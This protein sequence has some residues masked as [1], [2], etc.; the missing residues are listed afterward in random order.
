METSPG[1]EINAHALKHP[2]AGV[3]S[4]SDAD[5]Q[6]WRN[7]ALSTENFDRLA[8]LLCQS[9]NVLT[10][11]SKLTVQFLV[12]KNSQR[13]SSVSENPVTATDFSVRNYS[14]ASILDLIF[15]LATVMLVFHGVMG[16]GP[17]AD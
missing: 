9:N 13:M 11:K 4:K 16:N 6:N 8:H 14:T 17:F 12:I 5:L 10:Q 2:E 15:A 3:K 7:S 1:L